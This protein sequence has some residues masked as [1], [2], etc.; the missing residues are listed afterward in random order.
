M[1]S[2]TA[3]LKSSHQVPPNLLHKGPQN[4]F[5]LYNI[6]SLLIAISCPTHIL[7]LIIISQCVLSVSYPRMANCFCPLCQFQSVG[8]GSPE[9]RL[10]KDSKNI[11]GPS[12]KG[13]Y[14]K[15][16][17]SALWHCSDLS[18]PSL[19]QGFF[20]KSRCNVRVIFF[21]VQLRSYHLSALTFL[22]STAWQIKSKL[23][24]CC[25]LKLPNDLAPNIP[26]CFYSTPPSYS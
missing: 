26:S 14:V 3:P 12:R 15:F 16:M 4:P 10:E 1:T 21:K 22:F 13:F 11:S 23:F 24:E 18:S 17:K 5:L 25:H 6:L 2:P 8:N 20:F 9:C 7:P 19:S